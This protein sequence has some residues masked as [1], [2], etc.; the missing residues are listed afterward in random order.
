MVGGDVEPLGA[1]RRTADATFLERLPEPLVHEPLLGLAGLP[2][3]EYGPAV[4]GRPGGVDQQPFRPLALA[5]A[6]INP[7]ELV[8]CFVLVA[9]DAFELENQCLGHRLFP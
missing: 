6:H 9:P 8:D 1:A 7:E 4:L 3:L 2:D 5:A